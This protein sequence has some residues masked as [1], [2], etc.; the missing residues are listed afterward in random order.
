[1]NAVSIARKN[2]PLL[3]PVHEDHSPGA[4]KQQS[5]LALPGM[6]S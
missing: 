2:D 6:R 3:L 1:M 4:D 5:R